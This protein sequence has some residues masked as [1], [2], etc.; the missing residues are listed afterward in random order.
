MGGYNISMIGNILFNKPILVVWETSKK[1]NQKCIGCQIPDNS[2]IGQLTLEQINTIFEKLKKFGVKKVF[3]Q[4]GEPLTRP[5]IKETIL[6]LKE[7]GFQ[8][9]LVCNGTLLN[10]DMIVFLKENKIRLGVSL[11]S[12]QEKNYAKIR[13]VNHLNS[14][15]K[16]LLLAKEV[17]LKVNVHCTASKMNYNEV[18]EIKAFVEGLGMRLSVLPYISNIGIASK[19][20]EELSY[21]HELNDIFQKLANESKSNEIF[22]KNQY[23]EVIQFLNK[24]NLGPCDALNNSIYMDAFGKISPCIEFRTTVDLHKQ[25]PEELYTKESKEAVKNCYTNT[26]CYYGCTR[27][28]SCITKNKWRLI[29][30][31]IQT[32]SSI[33]IEK[34]FI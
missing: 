26:P 33:Q 18:M 8:Q 29:S 31:P 2:A 9:T 5:D 27:G 15:K 34:E 28:I 21:Q 25:E 22:R 7:K 6:L 13:G 16:N 30:H 19:H 11:D 10:R 4:G 1:C 24:K 12:L 32:I 3:L 14:V 23:E 20:N 17:G